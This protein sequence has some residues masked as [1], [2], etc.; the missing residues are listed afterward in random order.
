MPEV[1]P[2]LTEEKVEAFLDLLRTG[3][4]PKDGKG[5]VTLIAGLEGIKSAACAVQ[6]EA[7]AEF[8]AVR[9][10]EQS[11]AGVPAARQ[12]RGVANE[13]ALARKESPRRGQVLLGLGKVLHSELTHTRDRLTDGS[14]NE[15]RAMLIARETACL[16]VEHRIAID[17]ALCADPAKLVGV[18]TRELISRVK[19][20]AA[21]LD[22]GAMAKRARQAE[23][24]RKVTVRP[25]PDTMGYVTALLPVAQPVGGHS[26]PGEDRDR[27][28][29]RS[30]RRSRSSPGSEWPPTGCARQGSAIEGP[31][32]GGPALLPRDRPT[33]RRP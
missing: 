20:L 19:R 31:A 5:L 25:A 29:D 12:G 17:E 24:D 2:P 27:L 32:D 22:P 28:G 33:H 14:L 1:R 9:R 8:D 30:P 6:A 4:R 26:E 11:A 10:A 3:E 16:D 18:G 7:S 23:A 21:K 13:V 15:F